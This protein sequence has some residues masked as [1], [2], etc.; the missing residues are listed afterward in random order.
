MR[1]RG[2]KKLFQGH[3]ATRGRQGENP[4]QNLD[5]LKHSALQTPAGILGET[6]HTGGE[7]NTGMLYAIL[8][9]F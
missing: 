2:V 7:T 4:D 3:T 6:G 8:F 1:L 5:T 9:H